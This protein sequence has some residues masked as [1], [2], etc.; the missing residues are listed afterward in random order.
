[1]STSGQV[2][3]VSGYQGG[4]GRDVRTAHGFHAGTW[5]GR[6]SGIGDPAVSRRPLLERCD[7]ARSPLLERSRR[8][9]WMTALI[10]PQS[11]SARLNSIQFNSNQLHK[12]A[13]AHVMGSKG[14]Q[15]HCPRPRTVPSLEL[16]GKVNCWAGVGRLELVKKVN[17]QQGARQETHDGMEES[18]LLGRSW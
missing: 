10:A 12:S 11:S 18:G 9:S 14:N 8:I 7:E 3:T 1:M 17:H 13:L 15:L 2:R 6:G 16:V 5:R 4:C